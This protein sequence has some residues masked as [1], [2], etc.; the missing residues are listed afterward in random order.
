MNVK[1]LRSKLDAIP[2]N[3]EM[4]IYD[5]EIGAITIYDE[6]K[7]VVLSKTGPE[8]ENKDY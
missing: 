5:I 6:E 7:I 1:E 4:R 3:Y 2:D 8:E